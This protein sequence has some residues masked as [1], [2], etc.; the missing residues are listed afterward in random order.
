MGHTVGILTVSCSRTSRPSTGT[1]AQVKQDMP[2]SSS[3]YRGETERNFG[4]T[5]QVLWQ[6]S[7]W[8]CTADSDFLTL[9]NSLFPLP[10]QNSWTG[11]RLSSKVVMRVI[12]TL[13]TQ[14]SDLEG[15]RRLPRIGTHVGTIGMPMSNLWE[16]T[17]YTVRA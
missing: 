13:R 12:S 8:H 16:F 9:L 14:H 7:A 6:Q 4:C 3:T 10:L 1:T 17:D 2:P 5:L 15:W 11:F